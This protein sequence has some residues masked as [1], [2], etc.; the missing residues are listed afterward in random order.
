MIRRR[1]QEPIRFRRLGVG[2]SGVRRS[3]SNAM[4]ARATKLLK[5]K[6]GTNHID[7]TKLSVRRNQKGSHANP[8]SLTANREAGEYYH[9]GG[10]VSRSSFLQDQA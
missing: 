7:L 10:G 6:F 3:D 5:T 8:T 4:A 2:E 1:N 9:R